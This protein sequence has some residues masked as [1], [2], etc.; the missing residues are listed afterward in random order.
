MHF[1]LN[2]YISH[3]III[4]I[5][6]IIKHTLATLWKIKCVNETVNRLPYNS[7]VRW[8]E[9][10]RHLVPK[11]QFSHKL[12]RNFEILLR[13]HFPGKIPGNSQKIVC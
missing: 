1:L 10:G 6:I 4:I 7:Q 8:I 11:Q 12:H 3:K 9:R 2:V 13:F 5:I